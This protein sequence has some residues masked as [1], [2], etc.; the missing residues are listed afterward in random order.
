MKLPEHIHYCIDRLEHAGF[1][2]YAVGGCVRDYLLGLI[3]H[4]YDLCTA[5][6]P[7]QIK[8]I[9]SEHRLVLSGEKHGTITI[10]LAQPVEITT[11]RTEGGYAD[12]R[13][14]DWVQFVTDIEADLSR[15]DFT[16]NAMAFSPTR[17]F[18]DPFGGQKD[19]QNKILR[20][21][22]DPSQRFTEDALRIL[23]GARFAVRY[24]LQVEQ[25][26]KHAM[27]QLADRMEGLARERVLDE[28]CKLLPLVTAEDLLEFAPLLVQVIPELA[29]CVNF[30]Q[31]SPHHAYDVYSH[32]AQVVAATPKDLVL[33]WAALLHDV[34]KPATFCQDENGRGHFPDHASVGAEM[35][36]AILRRLRA[37]N[38]LREQVTMLIRYHMTPLP[39]EKTILRRRLS[40]FGQSVWSLLALQK[41]DFC[42]KGVVAKNSDF[43]V[44]EALLKEI[45]EENTCLNLKD[46]A[47]NGRDLMALGFSGKAVGQCLNHLLSQVL[48]EHLT[49]EKSTLLTAAECYRE[50]YL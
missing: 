38:P 22:G 17:G 15:R 50:K 35:A 12:S 36:D 32:T 23:R 30:D 28:L 45:A 21:V 39:P 43:A 27:F 48:D 5:A 1:A 44:T 7:A 29:G 26:T 46:L 6:T 2:T 37:S 16:V 3:P 49:N 14:P 11:F 25:A 13:H 41:A 19:L 34:G 24:H 20:A 10:L 8:D 33:R 9:F 42:S 40:K 47:V 4:D 18:A 31:H